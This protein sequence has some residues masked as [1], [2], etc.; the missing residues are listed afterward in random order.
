MAEPLPT[1]SLDQQLVTVLGV[2]GTFLRDRRDLA[3][4]PAVGFLPAVAWMLRLT[5]FKRLN[6][7]KFDVIHELEKAF[8]PSV[9][10]GRGIYEG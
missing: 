8:P 3:V 7:V 10:H 9:L 5:S 6:A 1:P 2:P 4:I